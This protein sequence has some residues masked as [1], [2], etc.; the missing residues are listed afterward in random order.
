[1]LGSFNCQHYKISVSS[2]RN[3]RVDALIFRISAVMSKKRNAG[4]F[5]QMF[6]SF[7]YGVMID[8]DAGR[9]IRFIV[10]AGPALTGLTIQPPCNPLRKYR[11][12]V[13]RLNSSNENA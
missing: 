5:R 11:F 4:S 9:Q 7:V 10:A 8:H 13:D 3:S 12:D 1:M 6:T 2:K